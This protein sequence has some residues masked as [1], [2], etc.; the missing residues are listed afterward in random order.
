MKRGADHRQPAPAHEGAGLLRVPDADPDRV[1][2]GG[3][4]RLSGALA[5]PSR[6]VLRAAAGAAA[7]QAA[8]HGVGLRSLFPDRALLPRRG[9]ARRPLARRVLSA[10]HR[11]ELRHPGRRVRRGRA[12]AARRVRGIC[13]RQAGDAEVSAHPLRGGDARIRH[14]QARPAQPDQDAGRVGD[15]PRLRL[16]GVCAHPRS[17]P[18]GAGVGNSGAGRRLARV[19][20]PHERLG[21]G[22]RPARLG[23]HLLC[24]G[25]RQGVGSRPGRQQCRRREDRADPRAAWFEGWRRGVLRRRRS[26]GV[27]EI[28]RSGAYQ[29]RHRAR[30]DRQGSLRAVLDRRLPDVRMERGGEEDRLLP[31]PVLDAEP[32]GRRISRARSRRQG[33]AARHQGDPVRRRLQRRRAVL[34]RDPEPSPGRDEEGVR[35]RRLSGRQC[36]RRSSAAC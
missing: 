21:A 1:V 23:L 17:Q 18:E 26:G 7:V 32:S 8:H 19:L 13:R 6:K 22:R 35:H 11:D 33:Q 5:H 29:G 14:R 2:A 27:R 4:A 31:Q 9:C 3:R 15:L 28:C 25:G 10:R 24:V 20:R 30:S 34:R 16:Q 36:C 12:G